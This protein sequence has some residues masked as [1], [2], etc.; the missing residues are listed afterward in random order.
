MVLFFTLGFNLK[1]ANGS[2]YKLI[3]LV[4]SM[5]LK[6]VMKLDLCIHILTLL[7]DSIVI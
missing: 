2:F 7:V 3:A 1:E 6:K 5:Y 4:H